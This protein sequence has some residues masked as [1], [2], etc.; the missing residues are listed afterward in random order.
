VLPP[1]RAP[2]EKEISQLSALRSI[3]PKALGLASVRGFLRMCRDLKEQCSAWVLTDHTRKSAISRRLDGKVWETTG[4]KAKMCK[5]SDGDWPIGLNES[6]PFDTVGIVEGTP[7][8]LSLLQLVAN[9]ALSVLQKKGIIQRL[10]FHRTFVTRCVSPGY[11]A[12]PKFSSS[13]IESRVVKN[14]KA[15]SRVAKNNKRRLLKTA[16]EGCCFQ[17]TDIR[18]DR[19]IDINTPIVPL[20]GDGKNGRGEEPLS[21]KGETPATHKSVAESGK[22]TGKEPTPMEKLEA[23]TRRLFRG[24]ASKESRNVA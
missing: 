1:I 23:L 24:V 2:T 7:D 16:S 18:I 9:H 20:N 8:F 14:S 19:K 4:K 5:G 11:S 13:L 21:K 22:E 17:Q 15:E 10:G 3:T 12:D 6:V